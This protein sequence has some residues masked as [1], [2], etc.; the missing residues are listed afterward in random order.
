MVDKF[1]TDLK[2]IKKLLDQAD[3]IY[4]SFSS[5]EQEAIIEFHHENSTLAHCLRW[6]TQGVGELLYH[7]KKLKKRIGE[8]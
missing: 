5:Q 1:K 3:T 2:E 8:M 6:G 7:F 4:N